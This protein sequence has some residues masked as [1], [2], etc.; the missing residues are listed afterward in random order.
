[1]FERL[2]REAPSAPLLR[3]LDFVAIDLETTGLHA[4]KGDEVVAMAGIRIAKG[5]VRPDQVFDRLVNPGRPIPARV[6]A[7][8]GITDRMVAGQAGVLESLTALRAFVGDAAIVGYAAAF[9][10]GFLTRRRQ[11]RAV[12]FDRPTL[13]VLRLSEYL[14]PSVQDHSLEAVAG[15]FGVEILGRHTALGDAMAAAE[16]F[17]RMLPMLEAHGVRTVLQAQRAARRAHFARRLRRGL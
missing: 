15:R 12:A 2:L 3:D 1:M 4:R 11:G 9:D 14:D 16:I 13:C 17:V 5:Q 7:I 8:H 10:L 6:V